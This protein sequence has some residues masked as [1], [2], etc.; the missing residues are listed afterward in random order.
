[1]RTSSRRCRGSSLPGR[2]LI[3]YFSRSTTQNRQFLPVLI[4]SNSQSI[5]TR[6]AVFFL[7]LPACSASSVYFCGFFGRRGAELAAPDRRGGRP[8]TDPLP[9]PRTRTRLWGSP[10]PRWH[11][12]RAVRAPFVDHLSATHLTT[13]TIWHDHTRQSIGSAVTH[14]SY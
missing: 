8:S 7:Q 10:R 5:S 14:L 3:N 1:M 4:F 6:L 9:L 11:R 2:F 13:T 12:L